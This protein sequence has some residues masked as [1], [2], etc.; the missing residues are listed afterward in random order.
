MISG[1][2]INM[3]GVAVSAST[4]L[5]AGLYGRFN[6]VTIAGKASDSL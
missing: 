6:T 2:E 4:M 5:N 1:G 3:T